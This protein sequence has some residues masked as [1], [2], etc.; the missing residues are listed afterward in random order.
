MSNLSTPES[1]N[2][3]YSICD[4]SKKFAIL[5]HFLRKQFN[6]NQNNKII[7]FFSTCGCVEYFSLLL[8]RL[9][10]KETQNVFSIHRQ[11]SKREKIFNAFRNSKTGNFNFIFDLFFGSLLTF[12]SSPHLHCNLTKKLF[13]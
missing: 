4:P 2:N 5:V 6:S 13:V 9:L 3:F 7:V 11:K 10:R 8:K 12:N 1:L